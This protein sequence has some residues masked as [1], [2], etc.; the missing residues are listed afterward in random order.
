MSDLVLRGGAVVD[1]RAGTVE[2]R[3]VV[4][5][6]A[7]IEA[8]VAPG[9]AAAG[10]ETIDVAGLHVCP[11]FIDLRGA[12]DGD[13]DRLDAL[14]G[15]FTTV[16]TSGRGGAA[17]PRTVRCS[18]LF[19]GQALGA[20]EAGTSVLTSGY[21][22]PPSLGVLR[23]ALLYWRDTQVP[24]LVH[25]EDASLTLRGVLGAGA[26]AAGLGL[27]PV[28]EAAEAAAVAGIIEV[29]E[30]CGGALHLNHLTCAGSLRLVREAK[31]RGLKITADAAIAHACSDDSLALG[32]AQPARIWPPLRPAKHRAAVVEALRDGTLDAVS[33]DHRP[34]QAVDREHTFDANAPGGRWSRE[35][36]GRLCGLG[37]PLARVVALLSSGPAGIARL[38]GGAL[39]TGASADLTV[40]DAAKGQVRY[41]LVNGMVHHRGQQA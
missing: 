33:S 37:L 10:A 40:V 22:A 32:Y 14:A 15:G 17:A 4:V 3:D 9:T 19:D 41:T 36:F 6:G 34:V 28:P 26:T 11:G 12:L 8:L 38:E 39:S 5:R 13:D 7:R 23:R 29:L 1:P 18:A 24:L 27:L 2:K 21:Q 31:G 20:L 25:A 16:V 35:V 30:E